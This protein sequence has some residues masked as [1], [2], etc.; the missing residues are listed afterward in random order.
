VVKIKE[1]IESGVLEA[2]VLGSASEAEAKELLYLKAKHPQ[3]LE[4]L[5]VLESDLEH[6]AQRMAVTPPPGTWMKIESSINE[7]MKNPE[8]LTIDMPARDRREYANGS[9]RAKSSQFLEIEAESGHIRIRK[10]WRWIFGAVFLLGKIFL[11]FA[12]YYYIENR[13]NVKEIEQLK[14]E[15]KARSGR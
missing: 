15:L 9:S 13:H 2:Y 4:A 12:I 5:E 10:I 14:I 11:A 3:I 7:L 1:Y 6:I 8:A